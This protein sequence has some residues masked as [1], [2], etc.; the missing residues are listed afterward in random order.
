MQVAVASVRRSRRRRC[1]A[2]EMRYGAK[3]TVRDGRDVG[4][5]GPV[6][7]V[8]GPLLLAARPAASGRRSRRGCQCRSSARPSQLVRAA[9]STSRSTSVRSVIRPSTPRSSRSLHLG[10]VVDGPHVHVP[11][12]GVRALDEAGGDHLAA[13]A[14]VRHLQRVA[15]AR[16]AAA[17]PAARAAARRNSAHPAAVRTTWRPAG[18]AEPA[19]PPQ[20]ARRRTT[21]RRPGRAQPVRSTRSASAG[22]RAV[23]LE[24]DVEPGV[25]G[26]ARAGRPSRDRLA[27]ADQGLREVGVR[28]RRRSRRCRSVTRSRTCVVEGQQHAVA[29]GVHVGLEVA[30]AQRRPRARRRRRVFSRPTRS[31]WCAPPRCANASTR[32][33][34]PDRRRGTGSPVRGRVTRAVWTAMRHDGRRIAAAHI[35]VPTQRPWRST[36][37]ACRVRRR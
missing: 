34:R 14:A 31:G 12:G 37:R 36:V 28:Q 7:P 10:G 19:E 24:V 8:P 15:A 23:G 21:R 35:R 18:R 30:V 16:G 1:S 9:R 27:P 11:A 6:V 22:D 25:A 5:V 13:P 20:P 29:G 26:S 32:A 2:T 4:R 3:S 17:R 33:G